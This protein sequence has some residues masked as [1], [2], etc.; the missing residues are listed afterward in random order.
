[1]ISRLEAE[2]NAMGSFVHTK[3]KK[4][5]LWIAMD[6]TGGSRSWIAVNKVRQ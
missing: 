2:A 5:W 3:A 4:Q 6:A 1:V